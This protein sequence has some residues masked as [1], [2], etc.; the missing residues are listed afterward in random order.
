[1]EGDRRKD[2]Q[3]DS[4][5]APDGTWGECWLWGDWVKVNEEIKG[6]NKMLETTKR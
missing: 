4:G 6:T 5:Y 3:N 1:M 2:T